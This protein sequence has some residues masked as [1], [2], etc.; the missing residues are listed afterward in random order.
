MAYQVTTKKSYGQRLSGSFKG[1]ASGFVMFIAGTV[2]LFWNEG[3]FVKT[4]KALQEAEK[5]VVIVPDV[6]SVDAALN[7]K[8]IHASAFADTK[9]VLT[10]GLFGVSET[11]VAISRKVEYYQYTE[12]S[13]TET[14]NSF[15]GEEETIIVYDYEAQWTST[16]VN[17]KQFS[18]PKYQSSNFVLI[19]VGS[20]TEYAKD[21]TF[22][23]Y[24]LPDFI[25]SSISG[26]LPA[27]VKLNP[28]EIKQLGKVIVDNRAARG[29]TPDIDA[30]QCVHVDDNVVYFGIS[31]SNPR[32]GDVRVTL[33]KILPA[34]ISIIAKVNG[35]TFEKYIA[36]NGK[37]VSSVSM[38][39]VSAETMFAG[40]HAT[41][42][43]WAWIFRLTGL[44]LVIGGLKSMFSILPTL[45]KIVPFLSNIVDAGVGLVCSVFGFAWSII[46]IAIAWLWYRPVIGILLLAIAITGIWFLKKKAKEKKAAKATEKT[47]E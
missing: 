23:G 3:N 11:A 5:N 8:L 27:E 17:S 25:I 38:G 43:T 15:G 29:L 45:F 21:V 28:E 12:T 19:N 10:D 24:R 13:H 37:A 31:T 30:M 6:S 39:T 34:D 33:T 47:E 4:Q 9:D 46:I 42:R 1:I 32:I 40:E 41:N 14:K 7:G 2:L 35:S 16:Q 36:K 20:K 26:S 22:G 44:L 18:N